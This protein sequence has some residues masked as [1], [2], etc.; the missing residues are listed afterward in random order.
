MLS[1]H[2]VRSSR[3]RCDVP[4]SLAIFQHAPSCQCHGLGQQHSRVDLHLYH[5]YAPRGTMHCIE[6]TQWTQRYD[7][8]FLFAVTVRANITMAPIWNVVT[9]I[10]GELDPEHVVVLGNHRD[11]WVAG[12]IDPTCVTTKLMRSSF[13]CTAVLK[14]S[15]FAMQIWNS[16]SPR[17]WEGTSSVEGSRVASTPHDRV[18]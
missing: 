16:S 14:Q 1:L 8:G 4:T 10:P 3:E 11:A 9:V 15:L 12:A 2:T 18:V 6:W 5:Q 7:V 13:T 17:D